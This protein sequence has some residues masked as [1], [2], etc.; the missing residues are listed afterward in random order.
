MRLAAI[1]L[2]L[3]A[4]AGCSIRAGESKCVAALERYA[5]SHTALVKEQA[6]HRKAMQALTNALGAGAQ[7]LEA[8]ADRAEIQIHET[9]RIAEIMATWQCSPRGFPMTPVPSPTPGL[10]GD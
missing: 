3:V 8:E 10:G 9:K 2:T 1:T 6:E 5:R 7:A 4:L